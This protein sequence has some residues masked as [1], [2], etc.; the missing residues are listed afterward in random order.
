MLME[1]DVTDTVGTKGTLFQ[2]DLMDY[3]KE[4]GL[5]PLNRADWL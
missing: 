3:D 5:F 4:T 1:P 2:Q